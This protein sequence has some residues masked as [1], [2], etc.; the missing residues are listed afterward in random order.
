M[1]DVKRRLV[2]IAALFVIAFTMLLICAIVKAFFVAIPIK[3]IQ[4]PTE[5]ERAEINK[6]HKKH[7]V[8]MSINH[9]GY[10][11]FIRDGKMCE[12]K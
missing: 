2:V 11:Y 10:V 4:Q 12:L 5:I 7:G 9:N 1:R 8:S 3:E 6:L